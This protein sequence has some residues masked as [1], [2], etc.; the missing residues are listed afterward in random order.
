[1]GGTL[2]FRAND[3]TNG[4]ELFKSDA[5]GTG[6]VEDINPT[7]GSSPDWLTDVNGTLFFSAND[8]TDGNELW[9]SDGSSAGTFQVA[10][11]NPGAGDSLPGELAAVGSALYFAANDGTRGSELWKADQTPT[12]TT[13]AS[14]ANP[15]AAGQVVTF[16]ATVAAQ[17]GAPAGSVTFAIDGAVQ[18][19]VT[20]AGG[21]AAITATLAPGQHQITAAFHGDTGFADSAS[22]VLTQVVS[23][24]LVVPPP[25]GGGTTLPDRTAPVF[26]SAALSR[27]V[28][29]VN[30]RGSAETPVAAAKKGTTFRYT[31]SEA[32]RVVVTIKRGIPGRKVGGRCVKP[33]RANRAAPRCV[34]YIRAGRFAIA[35]PAG[36][37]RHRFSGRIGSKKLPVG[38]YRAM[39]VAT[40]AAGN[41]SAS[42][43]LPFWVVSG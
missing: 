40:D 36:A 10:D 25:G 43:R 1:M 17:S 38:G 5:G 8:G 9:T 33:R 12:S 27:T 19:P 26:E 13:L 42:K 30:P 20:L 22:P 21:K 32:A 4:L 18:P 2:F 28:F 3:G 39:L 11:I 37:T 41:R 16:T 24:P 29:A 31:L 14:S 34:R 35:S 6:L 7:E 15:A 23:S